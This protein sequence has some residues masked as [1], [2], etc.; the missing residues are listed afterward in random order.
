MRNLFLFFYRNNFTLFFLLL[1]GFCFFL[2]IKNNKYQNTSFFN[3][4]NK[5]TAS[6]YESVSYIR[7]YIS[8]KTKSEIL[9]EENARFRSAMPESF[10]DTSLAKVQVNDTLYNQ[11]YTYITAK[12]I[13]NSVNSRNNY[14]TLNKGSLSGIQPEMGVI[15]SNGVVGIIKDVSPHYSTVISFLHSK[16]SVS[17]RFKNNNYFGALMWTDDDDPTTGTLKEIPKHIVFKKGD[18]IV[19]TSFSSIYPE[20]IFLGTVKSFVI[21]P[22]DNFYTTTISLSADFYSLTHVYV[23]TN[24]FKQEQLGLEE[25]LKNAD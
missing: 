17:A 5:I 20:N 25:K 12:V 6:V 8:L 3:S 19:T 7:D 1:E 10:Y 9:A 21:K 16:S 13:N 11:Q 24:L 14:L 15:G 4:T 2:M 18:S 23:V 22:G